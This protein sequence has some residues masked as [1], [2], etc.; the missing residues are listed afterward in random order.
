LK[1]IFAA[2]DRV[3]PPLAAG[4]YD[5]KGA[6]DRDHFQGCGFFLRRAMKN[7]LPIVA[8]VLSLVVSPVALAQNAAE[9]AELQAL[10]TAV[11][12]DKRALVESTVQPTPAE[13]KKFWPIYDA[14]QRAL[15]GINRRRVV[16]VEALI[17]RDKAPS[18]LYARTL[19][20]ELIATDEAEIK[21][22]RRMHNAVLKAL[23]TRKAA[24]YLQ[25]ESK[26]RAVQAYDLAAAIPLIE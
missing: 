19:A 5:K 17:G 1:S 22:R 4:N 15:D 13:A 3:K 23:P 16:A 9:T 18:D 10:R 2:S 21:A 12:A 11:R 24:R 8:C 6:L 7:Y 14:Y 20:A 25:L 26:I